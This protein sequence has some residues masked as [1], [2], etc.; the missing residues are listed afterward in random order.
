MKSQ[1][2]FL[3]GVVRTVSL[4]ILPRQKYVSSYDRSAFDISAEL[5]EDLLGFG[6]TYARVAQVLGVSRWTISHQRSKRLWFRI[7]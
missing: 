4:P 1:Q 2:N 6:I 7:F 5:L 3:H